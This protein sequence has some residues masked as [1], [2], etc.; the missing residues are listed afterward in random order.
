MVFFTHKYLNVETKHFKIEV[1]MVPLFVHLYRYKF[2]SVLFI[3]TELVS[4]IM[5]MFLEQNKS[6]II[7]YWKVLPTFEGKR[8]SVSQW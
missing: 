4:H 2:V 6:A 1:D 8:K 7:C 5:K 3:L